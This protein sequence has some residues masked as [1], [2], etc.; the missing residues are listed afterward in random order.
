M[1]FNRKV[2]M[3]MKQGYDQNQ[4]TALALGLPANGPTTQ[5]QPKQAVAPKSAPTPIKAPEAVSLRSDTSVGVKRKRSR[6]DQL[7][8]TNRGISSAFSYAPSAG[9]GGFS[10]SGLGF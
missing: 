10:G 4:A 9:L 1:N 5:P 3:Y 2:Q 6:R 7:G 8:L